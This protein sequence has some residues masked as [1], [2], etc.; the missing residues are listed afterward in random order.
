MRRL[1][2]A[3]V[4]LVAV[5]LVV[6]VSGCGGVTGDPHEVADHVQVN[7]KIGG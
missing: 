2:S 1:G 4:A 7:G 3:V 5:G 6:A